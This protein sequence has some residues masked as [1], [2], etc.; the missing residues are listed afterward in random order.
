[1]A[2]KTTI[3]DVAKRAQVSVGTVHRAIYGKPGVS[4]VVRERILEIAHEMGYQPNRVASSLRKKPLN[5]VVAFPAPTEQNRF[6]YGELWNGCQECRDLFQYHN[7]T[8]IEVPYNEEQEN[9]FS[10]I[11]GQVLLQNNQSIDGMLIGGK[12]R[13]EDR[14]LAS[15]VTYPP[16]KIPLIAV[17]E[18]FSDIHCLCSIQSDHVTDGR[19]AAEL[20]CPQLSEI[21]GILL[22]SGDPDMQ[23]NAEN[24]NAFRDWVAE[25][26]PKMKVFMVG[27]AAEDR[28]VL[29][30]V[31]QCLG[32]HPEI[33]G[34]YA[35]SA[36]GTL[37]I[38]EAAKSFMPLRTFRIIGSDLY[39]ESADYLRKGI[40]SSIIYKNPRNQ[41]RT[42]IQYMLDYLIWG[43]TPPAADQRLTSLIINRGNIHKYYHEE[44]EDE[45]NLNDEIQRYGNPSV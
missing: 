33:R 31:R 15:N 32:D 44:T 13:E 27:G 43:T 4:E 1:M 37:Q 26:S 41:A 23:S 34:L 10:S 25:Y 38:V 5:I 20:L 22:A 2:E 11:M 45:R 3:S 29:E 19:M 28:S 35:V 6:F 42:G 39:R 36:R 17:G 21:D 8:V 7:C 9:S 30:R 40:I 12:M 24:A 16:H 14:I 18:N